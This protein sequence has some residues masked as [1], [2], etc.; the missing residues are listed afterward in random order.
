MKKSILAFILFFS[1]YC[2]QAQNKVSDRDIRFV[3]KASES[4]LAEIRMGELA[5]TN[6]SS[7]DVKQLGQHMVDDH[8]KSNSDLKSLAAKKNITLSTSVSDKQQKSYSKLSKK[9]GEDFDKA[10]SKCMV[11]DHKKNICLF[12]KEAKKG[13][14]P[15][16]KAWASN[17]IPTLE[18]HK[19]MAKET[20]KSV[21]KKK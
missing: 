9:Q 18:H 3:K 1:V 17:S 7:A 6:A 10:Y 2:I 16:I 12:K 8:T 19:Q 21:R 20:C 4:N 11:K 14:D 13:K 15:E 5:R